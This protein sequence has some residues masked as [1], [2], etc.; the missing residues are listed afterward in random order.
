MYGLVQLANERYAGDA[1]EELE[2]NLTVPSAEELATRERARMLVE[3]ASR[4]AGQQ[5]QLNAYRPNGFVFSN[6]LPMDRRLNEGKNI[7]FY[8]LFLCF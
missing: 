6:Q 3:F 7:Y 2:A 4:P 1:D 8:F 5:E